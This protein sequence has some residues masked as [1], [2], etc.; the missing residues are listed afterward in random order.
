MMVR[1]SD[2]DTWEVQ[3]G[4]SGIQGRPQLYIRL[5][6]ILGYMRPSQKQK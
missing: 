4:E 2:P 5:E 1:S 6:A 3:A